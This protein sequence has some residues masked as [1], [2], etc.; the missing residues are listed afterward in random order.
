MQCAQRCGLAIIHVERLRALGWAVSSA[1][2]TSAPFRVRQSERTPAGSHRGH[3]PITRRQVIPLL[4]L[5]TFSGLRVLRDDGS[6][7]ELANQRRRLAVLAVVA[8]AY[9][10]GV[11]RD[12][13]LLLLWPD[14]DAERGRHALNQIVYNLRRELG[15]SPIDG[16]TELVLL[17]D[18]MTADITDFR[19]AIARGDHAVAAE[20]FTGPFLDGF[21]VPGATEFD[22]WVEDERQRTTRQAIGALE[23]L[24]A[25]ADA[26]SAVDDV[27]R[28]TGRLVELDPLSARRALVHMRALERQGEREAAIAY[29]RRSEALA[30]ADGDDVDPAVSTEVER[31]RSTRVTPLSAPAVP[32]S[33]PATP[34]I[35]AT[36]AASEN[37]AQDVGA[38][39]HTAQRVHIGSD[40][41]VIAKPKFMIGVDDIEPDDVATAAHTTARPRARWQAAALAAVVAAGGLFAWQGAR[42]PGLP[43]NRGDRIVIADVQLAGADTANAR[44]FTLA[45]QSALQQ[46]ARV[47][48]V[49]PVTIAD[50]LHRMGRDSSHGA[51]PDSVALEVA[52]RE[53]ARYVVSLSILPS[54]T[55]RQ[56]T[57]R[58][59]D[60]ATGAARRT[61]ALTVSQEQLLSA[62][63]DVTSQMRRD[64]GDSRSEVASAMPLPRATTASLEALRLLASAH[65]AFSRAS[66]TDARTLYVN[67]AALDTGFAA[68]YAGIAAVDYVNNNTVQGDS[69]MTRAL[70]LADRLPP[71]ER[72]LI[73][74]SAERGR[75]DWNKAAILHRAYLVRYPDDYDAYQLLGYDLMRAKN[76]LDAKIAFDS[77]AAHRPL[78]AN[79]WIN[80][81]AIHRQLRD[82]AAARKAQVAAVHLD[83]AVLQRSIQNEDIGAT[84]IELGFIDSARTVY[85]AMLNRGDVDRARAHRSLAYAD[86]YEGQYAS[87][88]QH[89]AAAVSLGSFHGGGPLSEARDRALLASTYID[90]GK[91]SEAR[92]QLTAATTLCIANHLDP[93]ALLWVGKPLARLGDTTQVR[94]LL[95]SARARARPTDPPQGAAASALE[96]EMLTIRG[97]WNAAES[98]ASRALAADDN[99]YNHETLAYVYERAG[100]SADARAAYAA[101]AASTYGNVAKESQQLVRLAP[102]ALIRLDLD[103]G[104]TDAAR[105]AMGR[106]LER[107]PTVAANLP[108][109][110]ALRARV[111]SRVTR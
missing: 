67:A 37:A 24:A 97:D 46:S 30:R 18:V 4:R 41:A 44:A 70:A 64:L 32:S 69:N 76:P 90:L 39:G 78:S 91:T 27:V 14:A 1:T 23:K 2:A 9:P 35:A 16:V 56:L 103:A 48:V 15:A 54:G 61:Y 50:V 65:T 66:Y 106:F 95:D 63:D 111:D 19:A 31:L 34:A 72:M 110:A 52:E 21:F 45:L 71:R 3:T 98:A 104:R 5:L 40:V 47:Q 28:W 88:V 29:G 43:L 59:L 82:Y 105:S 86:L 17:P 92:A 79:A 49:G 13:L 73:E 74:A 68:A 22:R 8:A 36:V 77:L 80:V 96:A 38:P 55:Q 58:A 89:L 94:V 33:V 108:M 102:L 84:L 100:R 25:L 101:I 83:T 7:S 51:L 26:A 107:W 99:A 6:T 11:S 60:A 81:A 75:G 53:G 20:L 57:L 109:L 12:R 85:A 87:A 10:S 62:I 42:P 93:R